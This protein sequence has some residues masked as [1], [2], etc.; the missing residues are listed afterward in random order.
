MPGPEQGQRAHSGAHGGALARRIAVEAQDRH[1]GEAPE[2]LDLPFG[3][4]GAHRRNRFLDPRRGERDHVHVAFD[5]H[6]PPALPRGR[7]GSVEVVQRSS[8]VEQGSVRRIQVLRRICFA[9]IEDASAKSDDPPAR[10]LD[11]QHQPA[12]EAVVGFLVVDRD[13]QAGL[14][15][16]RF[17]GY[18]VSAFLSALRPS[19]A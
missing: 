15:Q 16:H 7:A 8:L 12:A 11:G 9:A 2:Q 17:S 14:D 10:V 5:H 18:C 4:C 3:Q 1:V 13:E 6:D 19:G